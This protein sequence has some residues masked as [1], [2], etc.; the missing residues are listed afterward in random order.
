MEKLKNNSP[1]E[2]LFMRNVLLTAVTYAAAILIA[3]GIIELTR[4]KN[5]TNVDDKKNPQ[6]E[7]VSILSE[8]ENH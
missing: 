5:D 8:S 2:K 1:E 3:A 6:T 7:A 4:K